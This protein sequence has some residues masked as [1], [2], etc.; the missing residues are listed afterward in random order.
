MNEKGIEFK[1]ELVAKAKELAEKAENATFQEI[2]DLKRKWRKASSEDESLAEKELN[3]EFDKFMAEINSKAGELSQSV[4]EKKNAIIA[5]AK[6]LANTKTFKD[7]SAKMNELMDKWKA[8]GRCGSEKDKE[9]WAKF[10]EARDAFYTNKKAHFE[11]LKEGFAKS[12]EE[13][14]KL[15]EEAIKAN[16]LTNFK[17]IGTKMDEL[18]E[19]WKKLGSAGREFEDDLWAKFS[20]QRKAF[21]KKRKEYYKSMKETFATRT[22]QKKELIAEAKQ[23][24]ARSEFSEDEITSVR[25][26]RNKWKEIGSAG[27]ENED[28]LWEEFNGIVNKYY[29]NMRFYRNNR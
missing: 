20:E 7:T 12:K 17:E 14:E 6:E 26:L 18:M 27:R 21:Y 13:K 22:E 1:N 25:E 8:A 5:E 23:Y 29:D 2:N 4:E 24:L 19:E 10:K 16:E 11:N 9:L 15:I 3:D 28:T